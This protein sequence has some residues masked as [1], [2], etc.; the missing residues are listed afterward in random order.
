MIQVYWCIV[1]GIRI[2]MI[3]VTIRT[4]I[5]F[6]TGASHTS[7]VIAGPKALIRWTPFIFIIYVVR[8]CERTLRSK[9]RASWFIGKLTCWCRTIMKSVSFRLSSFWTSATTITA[10]NTQTSSIGFRVFRWVRRPRPGYSPFLSWI[11]EALPWLNGQSSRRRLFWWSNFSVVSR[12]RVK[13]DS[14]F[15]RG[16][17]RTFQTTHRRVI[18]SVI[19]PRYLAIHSFYKK[20]IK[21][22]REVVCNLR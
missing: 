19:D 11:Y 22:D 3:H 5:T 10:S 13:C 18:I 21:L 15:S 9:I 4:I 12:T 16:V 2:V 6:F 8:R 14:M 17:V 1:G 7:G 20:E